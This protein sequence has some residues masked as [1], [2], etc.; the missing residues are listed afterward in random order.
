M[1]LVASRGALQEDL[2][3]LAEADKVGKKFFAQRTEE[4]QALK[5]DKEHMLQ[6][7]KAAEDLLATVER[8]LAN[9]RQML[10]E[11]R[12]KNA[13]VAARLTN[14][15]LQMLERV[16]AATPAPASAVSTP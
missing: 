2:K 9:A 14:E 13:Q 12:A 10:T 15:Q 4:K 5:A 7:Q 1:E 16:N 8:Q 11:A 6:D 3:K